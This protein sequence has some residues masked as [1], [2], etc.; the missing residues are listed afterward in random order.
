MAAA[1]RPEPGRTPAR[2]SCAH[3]SSSFLSRTKTVS[4]FRKNVGRC[5]LNCGGDPFPASWNGR[6]NAKL[7]RALHPELVGS[8]KQEQLEARV[9]DYM[10]DRLS[11]CTIRVDD[12]AE[13]MRLEEAMIAT[14]AQCS[15][16]GPS[17]S[18]LGLSSPKAEIVASGLWQVQCLDATPLNDGEGRRLDDLI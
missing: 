10:R 3:A 18:W 5:L 14:V 9:T 13:R 17:A 8:A 4:I 2:N 7:S 1:A 16:C 12:K 15:E 6:P 11:F